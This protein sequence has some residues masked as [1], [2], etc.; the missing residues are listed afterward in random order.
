MLA[1][2]SRK[3]IVCLGLALTKQTWKWRTLQII[4]E[5]Y[6]GHRYAFV[7]VT[8]LCYDGS[9]ITFVK[10]IRILQVFRMFYSLK[11]EVNAL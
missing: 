7:E 5:S 1:E 6:F 11:Q 8:C 10:Q 2:V 4:F 9:Q 3:E